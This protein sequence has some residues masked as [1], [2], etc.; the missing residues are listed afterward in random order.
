MG[1]AKADLPMIVVLTPSQKGFTKYK[2]NGEAGQ[3]SKDVIAN[4]AKDFLKNKLPVYH[5]NE[6][7]PKEQGPAG[8]VIQ[9]VRSTW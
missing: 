3:A 4:F 9:V 6:P 7:A 1:L 5:K 8:S 2:Y